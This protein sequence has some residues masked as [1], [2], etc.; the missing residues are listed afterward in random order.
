MQSQ[1]STFPSPSPNQVAKPPWQT[2]VVVVGSTF[3]LTVLDEEPGHHVCVIMDEGTTV[4][5][6]DDAANEWTNMTAKA[7][8]SE[9]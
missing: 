9:G 2:V 4:P 7:K 5:T 1:L 3:F 6:S 8:G